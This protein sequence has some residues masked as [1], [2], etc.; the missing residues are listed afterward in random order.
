MISV[1]AVSKHFGA[2][3]AVDNVSIDIAKGEFFAILGASGSG[4]TTL[5]RVLAGFEIPSAGDVLIDGES[6]IDVLPNRRPT[7]MV[8]QNYAIFPHLNVAENIGYGLLNKGMS[9]REIAAKV[10]GMLELIRLPG[11]GARTAYELSGGERQRVALARAL[12]CQPKVLL[13]DEPLG[14]LDKQLREQ[15]QIELRQLQRKVGIT[16]VF[17]THDQ[18]EALTM[19]DRIAVMANGRI[20]QVDTPDKLYERPATKQVAKF[21]GNINLFS[22]TVVDIGQHV[23]IALK[24]GAI[25]HVPLGD[26]SVSPG[27][28]VTLAVRPEKLSIFREEPG[29][30]FNWLRGTLKAVSYAGDRSFYLV[31][32]KQI[33][34]EIKVVELNKT[35]TCGVLNSGDEEVYLAWPIES[36]LLLTK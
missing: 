13:L 20:I 23:S 11:Y 36:G 4:K 31:E 2:V 19:A 33:D 14:A 12:V 17:V 9:K 25:L 22:G 18:E 15:M 5:L 28:E 26:E 8:F 35:A 10:D 21:I 34:A 24:G 6:V 7:N 27:D 30:N 32:V 29:E 16:F 1:V 3:R